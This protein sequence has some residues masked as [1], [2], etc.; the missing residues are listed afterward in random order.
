MRSHG[1]LGQGGSCGHGRKTTVWDYVQE[2]EST[3]ST[4]GLD[5]MGEGNRGIQDNA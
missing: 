4:E 1:G 5:G 3:L 2:V